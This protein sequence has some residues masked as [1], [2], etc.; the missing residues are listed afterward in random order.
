MTRNLVAAA[1]TSAVI[2]TG[3]ATAVGTAGP[4]QSEQ[5]NPNRDRWA[6]VGQDG[7]ILQQ[8]GG[9]SVVNCYQANA[10]CYLDA[11]EDVT[12]KAITAEILVTNGANDSGTPGQLTGDTAAA[13][14]FSGLVACAPAGTDDTN[15]GNPGVLVVAP[16]NSDG[17]AVVA[18][19]KNY[20][21][22]V[23]VSDSEAR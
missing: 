16:R 22:Y 19:Q 23:T 3:I 20:A 15:G 13:P 2:A 17:S 1:V 11:G 14:C 7:R 6:L 18:P 4:G 12:G 5:G 9:F 21:F 10:N 8:T